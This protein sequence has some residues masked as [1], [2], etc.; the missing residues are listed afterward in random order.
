[1]TEPTPS[2]PSLA[3]LRHDLHREP[4]LSDHERHTAARI[5]RELEALQPDELWTGLGGHGIAAVFAGQTD[6]PTVLLRCE[7]DALPIHE[8]T[9]VPHISLRPG[10]AHACGH[11]GHMAILTGVAARLAAQRPLCGRVVLAYQPAEE[12]GDGGKRMAADPRFAALAADHAYALHN[13]PGQPLGA[14]LIKDGTFAVASRGIIIHLSGAT[15]HA[16]HPELG[17]SPGV[18]IAELLTGL[19]ALAAEPDFAGRGLALATVI[20]ARLGEVAFGTTP[21]DG[22]VM[23][24][25]RAEDD[26][27]M[28]KLANLASERA[29]AI[30]TEHGL[31]CEISWQDVFAA[32]VNTPA[33]AAAVRK[34]AAHLGVPSIELEAPFRWSEDFGSLVHSS[35][36]AAMFGLGSGTEQPP[37]HASNFDFPDEL[38]DRGV[39]L[40]EQLVRDQLG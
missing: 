27:M 18:A 12:T 40:F 33:A 19:P 16:A 28:A 34:A 29:A 2:T 36:Q 6:G 37:L 17:N 11:D 13:L 32:T 15:S 9:G 26:A 24:T 30:A 7:L 21:G 5:T 4:E 1:M 31:E 3:A 38:I 35:P 22:V 39:A 23:A 14:V 10:V 25:L 20:H 8:T